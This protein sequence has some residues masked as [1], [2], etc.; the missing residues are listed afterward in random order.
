MVVNGTGT[1]APVHLMRTRA[2]ASSGNPNGNPNGAETAFRKYDTY[3]FAFSF[4]GELTQGID[5][6]TSMNYSMTENTATFSDTLQGKYTAS[7]FGD[8]VDL[9]V[10]MLKL[11]TWATAATGYAPTV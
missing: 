2:M 6:S 8:M 10:A 4:D 5:Y 7:L 11:L 1:Q 3:R 9:I